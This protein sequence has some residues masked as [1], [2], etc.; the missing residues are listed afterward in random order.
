MT[1][2]P[3]TDLIDC[4]RR[5][6]ELRR[7]CYPGWVR[8]GRMVQAKADHEIQCMEGI[9][10]RLNTFRLVNESAVEMKENGILL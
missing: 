1:R 6:L 7:K 5:E 9:M 10:E 8:Q 2:L 3:I 4:A